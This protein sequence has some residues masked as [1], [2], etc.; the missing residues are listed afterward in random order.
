MLAIAPFIIFF[1]FST[2]LVNY[3]YSSMFI[4]LILVFSLLFFFFDNHSFFN[5]SHSYNIKRI[6]DQNSEILALEYMYLMC[7]IQTIITLK[8]RYDSYL[9]FIKSI[10]SFLNILTLASKHFYSISYLYF[11]VSFFYV[12]IYPI[13]ALKNSIASYLYINN[14]SD[15]YYSES[16]NIV[17]NGYTNSWNSDNVTLE[18]HFYESTSDL[19]SKKIVINEQINSTNVAN[20]EDVYGFDPYKSF[21]DNPIVTPYDILAKEAFEDALSDNPAEITPLPDH[22]ITYLDRR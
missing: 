14:F 6:S 20:S 13:S 17:E 4:Y 1:S 5:N 7:V 8:S 3:F 10:P 16:I 9:F 11:T 21:Y 19:I 12:H 18:T 2:I 15:L 22:C